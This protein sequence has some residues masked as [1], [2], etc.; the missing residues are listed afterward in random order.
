MMKPAIAR[1]SSWIAMLAA[2]AAFAAAETSDLSLRQAAIAAFA[3]QPSLAKQVLEPLV[4]ESR[5]SADRLWVLGAL[6]QPLPMLAGDAAA[7]MVPPSRQFLARQTPQGWQV[8]PEGSEA[9]AALLAAAPA[10]WLSNDELRAWQ[11][12]AAR[13][14]RLAPDATGLGLPW[15][16][17][18]AWSLTGGAHGYSGESQPY[19][20]IDFAGGDGRVLA[21]LAGVIYKSCVRNGSA[22]VKLVHDNGYSTTYYHMVKLSAAP[23]GQRV[24]KGAYLGTIGNGLPCG[25]STTGPH[26]HFSLIHQGQAEPVHRKQIGG[27]QFFA[28]NRAYQ[29]YAQRNGNRVNVGGR[30]VNYG[31]GDST[32][33]PGGVSGIA[34]P[35]NGDSRVNLRRAPSLS[36]DVAGSAA[37]G[38]QVALQCHVRGEMVNG[39]WGRTD[40]WNRTAAGH[41]ISDGFLD[42]GSNAPVAPPCPSAQPLW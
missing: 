38:E 6:T 5:V 20:S 11:S 4:E 16:E 15:Q 8:A 35:G 18:A 2:P 31:A 36:A 19:D 24:A 10:G 25:G 23:D 41:W 33:A 1:L 13:G 26:V 29:G 22:L 14:K 32:P 7:D 21:P 42:T 40:I 30:L 39:V 34:T 9:F 27:W 12:Q 28:G 37:R 3:P 17:G